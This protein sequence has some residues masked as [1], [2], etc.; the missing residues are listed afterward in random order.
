M[1]QVLLTD[2]IYFKLRERL[3]SLKDKSIKDINQPSFINRTAKFLSLNRA[4]LDR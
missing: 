2:G 3:L 4:V 1:R